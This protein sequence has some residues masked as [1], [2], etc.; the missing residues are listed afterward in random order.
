MAG[1]P[2]D[3][4]RV[5]IGF[6]VLLAGL[7]LSVVSSDGSRAATESIWQWVGIAAMFVGLALL[8]YPL[9]QRRQQERKERRRNY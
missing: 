8:I 3:D 2:I 6:I 1:K 5:R 9:W 7:V 4:W